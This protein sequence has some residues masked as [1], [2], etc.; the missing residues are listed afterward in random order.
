MTDR[1]QLPMEENSQEHEA[2]L[3]SRQEEK[4]FLQQRLLRQVKRAHADQI[5]HEFQNSPDGLINLIKK[6]FPG[7][8]GGD[9]KDC[10]SR[11]AEIFH[12][13]NED[14]AI[15]IDINNKLHRECVC[16]I[17]TTIYAPFEQFIK[18]TFGEECKERQLDRYLYYMWRGLHFF[19]LH[20]GFNMENVLEF[21]ERYKR[22]DY[23]IYMDEPPFYKGYSSTVEEGRQ[24]GQ[25]L[26]SHRCLYEE[27][28][29]L[30]P[31]IDPLPSQFQSP[32]KY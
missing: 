5:K 28:R 20:N 27:F 4:R 10:W 8:G 3:A 1:E 16:A 15:H 17:L 25:H 19:F 30:L 6:Q 23:V 24:F 22:N 9:S 7:N 31:E 14:N 18:E 32:S 21:I 12:K 11:I 29:K 26:T 13:L 2:Y